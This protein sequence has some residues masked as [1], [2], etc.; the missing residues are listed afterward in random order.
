M[1]VTE[2]I[3]APPE[4][5]FT[6]GEPDL[7]PPE[8]LAIGELDEQAVLEEELDNEDLLEQD[9][10][11]D[12]LEATLDDLVHAQDDLDDGLDDTVEGLEVAS[13]LSPGRG[14]P[15]GTAEAEPDDDVDD[16][17]DDT[18][19]G[20][21]ALL[22]VRLALVDDGAD[23]VGELALGDVLVRARPVTSEVAPC[24][25]GEFVCRSCFL[26]RSQ[27][28]LCDPVAL[29]CRDCSA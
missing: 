20:L 2:R 23:G 7:E 25:L 29:T 1:T 26:V 14:V 24:G 11:E 21:D 12:V 6:E 19:E 27:A 16:D 3:D 17:L 18:V 13:G 10:D 9:V 22:Q 4:P 15:V 28:Q 5:R 8:E